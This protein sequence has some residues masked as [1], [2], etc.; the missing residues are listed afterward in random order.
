VNPLLFHATHVK[1]MTAIELV[2]AMREFESFA[3]TLRTGG[4]HRSRRWPSRASMRAVESM[5]W[6]A[7]R[8]RARCCEE[9]VVR[10]WVA[11]VV[12]A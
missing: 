3:E 12:P 7:R 9:L 8:E 11:G 2:E 4:V 6:W 5:E 10:W 1:G